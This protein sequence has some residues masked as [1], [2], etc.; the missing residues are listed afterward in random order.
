MMD[1]I[2]Q[3]R[4]QEELDAELYAA[5][6]AVCRKKRDALLAATDWVFLPDVAVTEDYKAAIITYR[7][8]LRDFPVEFKAW[9]DALDPDF[10]YRI[11]EFNIPFPLKP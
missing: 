6:L 11:S 7:Q 10:H 2:P 8:A 3:E 9:Y 4:T 5:N 1:F